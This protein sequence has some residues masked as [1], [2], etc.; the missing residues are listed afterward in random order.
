MK[1]ASSPYSSS[2]FSSPISSSSSSSPFPHAVPLFSH[3]DLWL[4]RLLRFRFNDSSSS[5]I[6]RIMT[7][8]V[9]QSIS[10]LS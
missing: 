4:A 10:H 7:L 9:F 6:S 5:P 1:S 3:L 2:S 8:A